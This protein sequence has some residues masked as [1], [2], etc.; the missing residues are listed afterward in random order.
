LGDARKALTMLERHVAARGPGCQSI[1]PL[2][3]VR[4]E[5]GDL[6]K[7]MKQL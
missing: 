2:T 1:Y 6:R 3:N 5:L 7:R 4:K